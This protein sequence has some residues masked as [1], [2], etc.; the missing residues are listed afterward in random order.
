MPMSRPIIVALG[1]AGVLGCMGILTNCASHHFLKEEINGQTSIM[2]ER[3]I[4]FIN[5]TDENTLVPPGTYEVSSDQETLRL[6]RQTTN[7]SLTLEAHKTAHDETVTVP[8]PLSF[9]EQND[10]HVVL[11]LFPDG[12]AL[13]AIGSYS[14]IQSRAARKTGKRVS[15]AKIKRQFNQRKR[16]PRAQPYHFTLRVPVQLNNLSPDI[17]QFKIRCKTFSG[18]DATKHDRDIGKREV[19]TP[20]TN[21]Q[22][23]GTVVVKF[24]A[25]H[26][27]EPEDADNYYCSLTLHK[28][29]IG[30]RQPVKYGHPSANS[31]PAWRVSANETPFLRGTLA[32]VN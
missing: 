8:T 21:R 4:H 22:F 17:N 32:P 12:T 11:L 16:I 14:G 15:R 30:F 23:H 7:Q 31:I 18:N 19:I 28:P 13:E 5:T 26:G 20:V 25:D 6:T 10:E 2:L 3:P 29:G 27:K 9:S 24:N 1:L